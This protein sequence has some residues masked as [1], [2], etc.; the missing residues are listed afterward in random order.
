MWLRPNITDGQI[1][2]SKTLRYMVS[3]S[4][5]MFFMVLLFIGDE[6]NHLS[7]V[8]VEKFKMATINLANV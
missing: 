8:A 4:F 1:S 3:V 6:K 7:P 5:Y 2:G